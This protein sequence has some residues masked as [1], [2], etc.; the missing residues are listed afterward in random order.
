MKSCTLSKSRVFVLAAIVIVCCVASLAQSGRGRRRVEPPPP[1]EAPEKKIVIPASGDLDKQES[2]GLNSRFVLKNGLTIVMSE[3]HSKTLVSVVACVRTGFANAGEMPP[4]LAF[5]AGEMFWRGTI[6]RGGIPVQTELQAIGAR[7]SFRVECDRTSFQLLAPS[8]QSERAVQVMIDAFARPNLDQAEMQRAVRLVSERNHTL[9]ADGAGWATDNMFALAYA[10]HW[11]QRGRA[12]SDDALRGIT[13]EQLEAFYKSFLQPANAVV[14]VAGDVSSFRL[15]P[16]LQKGFGEIKGSKTATAAAGEIATQTSLRYATALSDGLDAAFVSIGYPLTQV[17][18][19]DYP[20]LKVLLSELTGGKASRLGRVLREGRGVVHSIDCDLIGWGDAPTLV[21]HLVVDP[22]KIDDAEVGF[23]SEIEKIRREL[24]SEGE[25]QRA[26]SML[27]LDHYRELQRVEG[28]AMRLAKIEIELGSYK[29]DF[30]LFAKT[31]AVT[32]AQVQ[33]LAARIFPITGAS[34]FEYLPPE[35]AARSFTPEK[36][37]ETLSILIPAVK[38][39]AIAA[40]Q[41]RN[42]E[43]IPAAEQGPEKR[44]PTESS[45]FGLSLLPKPVRIYPTLR[46]PSVFVREDPSLPIITIGVFFQGGRLVEGNNEEGLTELMLRAMMAGSK[47]KPAREITLRLEQ[48]AASVQVVNEPDY[49]GFLLDVVTRNVEPAFAMLHDII[50]SPAFE[51]ENLARVIQEQLND[52]QRQRANDTIRAGELFWRS[53]LP[54]HPY[55][56]SLF[57]NQSVVRSATPELVKTWYSVTI[58]RQ[59]PLGVIVGDTE[60]SALVSR[61]FAEGFIRRE[62]QTKMQ[63]PLANVGA[64]DHLLAEPGKSEQTIQVLGFL[65]G[66]SASDDVFALSVFQQIAQAQ[67]GAEEVDR[68]GLATAIEVEDHERLAGGALEVRIV[69]PPA[70]ETT[71][72]ASVVKQLGDLVSADIGDD[73]LQRGKMNAETTWLVSV[74]THHDRAFEYIRAAMLGHRPDAVDLYTDRL[75]AVT[76][77]DLKRVLGDFIRNDRMGAGVV[78]GKLVTPAPKVTEEK[79]AAVP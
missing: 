10:Q 43:S 28:R 59:Y 41:I 18:A 37:F 38:D 33:K 16:L 46:G 67:L 39:A 2:D 17:T 52:A 65:T 15:L 21:F 60:G 58:Q 24:P 3:D 48:L 64:G 6:S 42:G 79:K 11:M 27:E 45:K 44:Q 32:S 71:T 55:G 78:R 31:S 30:K 19:T 75:D 51:K 56:R 63:L 74:Q 69:S 25:L 12:V 4:E 54:A 66:R 50:E 8:D 29:E 57:G 20:V 14:V 13:K 22:E 72:R 62:P 61:F 53:I 1:P 68:T 40:D 73:T 70:N 47:S 23:F 77:A 34:V 9:P 36:Y 7:T 26:V 49:F 35:L 76:K 5:V